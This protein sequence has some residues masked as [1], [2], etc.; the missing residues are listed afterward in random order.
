MRWP[1]RAENSPVQGKGRPDGTDCRCGVR[2]GF[3]RPSA[4]RG[5]ERPE[6]VPTMPYSL[7]ADI[8]AALVEQVLHIAQRQ[9]EADVHHHRKT[10]DLRRSLEVAEWIAHPATL[11]SRAGRLKR[12]SSDSTSPA[13]RLKRFCSDTTRQGR[14]ASTHLHAKVSRAEAAG[15]LKST[16][17]MRQASGEVPRSSARAGPACRRPRRTSGG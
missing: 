5:H 7:V 17:R 10:D 16:T 13:R 11:R 14:A 15:P 1:T 3:P 4:R 9:R 2:E 6:P 12:L 8:D